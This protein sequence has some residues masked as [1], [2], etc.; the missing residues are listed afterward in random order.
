MFVGLATLDSESLLLLLDIEGIRAVGDWGLD[1]E[2][3]GAFFGL[4]LE[5]L[6][7]RTYRATCVTV[8]IG[9]P[10]RDT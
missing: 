4:A 6:C 1:S 3:R 5:L 10:C 9:Y 8:N 7:M 2:P